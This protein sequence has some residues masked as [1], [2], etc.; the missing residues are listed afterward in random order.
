MDDLKVHLIADLGI[1]ALEGAVAEGADGDQS[2]YPHIVEHLAQFVANGELKA[3]A[4]N[5]ES[6]HSAASVVLGSEATGVRSFT[7]TS[8]QGLALMNEIVHIAASMRLPIVMILANRSMSG[9]I[10][11]WNDHTD[12]M[13]IRDCGWIQVFA[14]NG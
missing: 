6:E 12:V 1:V 13:S 9:P 10:S 3:Q 5:V 4:V 14:N 7:C 11:I 8:S 2:L